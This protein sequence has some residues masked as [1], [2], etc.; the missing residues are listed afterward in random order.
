MYVVIIGYVKAVIILA[1][2]PVI[3]YVIGYIQ[4]DIGYKQAIIG[5]AYV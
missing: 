4:A 3:N 5:F 1:I 2:K